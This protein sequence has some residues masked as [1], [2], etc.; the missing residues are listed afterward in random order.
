MTSVNL[1]RQVARMVHLVYTGDF[2]YSIII[3]MLYGFY[4]WVFIWFS[5][6]SFAENLIIIAKCLFEECKRAKNHLCKY[7]TKW[8][9]MLDCL[10]SW[11]GQIFKLFI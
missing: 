4:I 1:W 7:E 3:R 6:M 2:L 9:A 11:Q 8:M 10:T 5:P